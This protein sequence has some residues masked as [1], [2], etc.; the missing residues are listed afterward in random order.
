MQN[1]IIVVTTT[2]DEIISDQFNK[3]IAW[4]CNRVYHGLVTFR[5]TAYAKK[6]KINKN[7]IIITQF[8]KNLIE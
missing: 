6:K 8:N 3:K 4:M 2:H 7:K 1:K 5:N